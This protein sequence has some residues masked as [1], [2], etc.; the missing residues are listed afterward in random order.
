MVPEFLCPGEERGV[1]GW[2]CGVAL[3]WSAS[4]ARVGEM[5]EPS[6]RRGAVRK[7]VDA[8]QGRGAAIMPSGSSDGAGLRE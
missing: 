5:P 7:A 6:S 8:D 4:Q 2:Y 1:P 3:L